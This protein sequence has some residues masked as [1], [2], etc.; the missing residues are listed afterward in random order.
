MKKRGFAQGIVVESPKCGWFLRV[1]G[2]V[3]ESPTRAVGFEGW[4]GCAQKF[5][6]D[7]MF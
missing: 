2:L 6:K 5:T 4:K 3:T 7:T 1:D